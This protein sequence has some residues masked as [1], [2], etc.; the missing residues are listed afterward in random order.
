V[1]RLVEALHAGDKK[2]LSSIF[3]GGYDIEHI[4]SY[5]DEKQELRQAVWDEWKKS[6]IS[7]NGLGNLMLWQYDL[8][9]SIK[10]KPFDEKRQWY[11]CCKLVVAENI[12]SHSDSVWRPAAAKDKLDADSKLLTDYLFV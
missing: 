3:M 6:G 4:C 2:D 11:A 10:N 9:R 8:N 1:C 7:I 12:S 5:H